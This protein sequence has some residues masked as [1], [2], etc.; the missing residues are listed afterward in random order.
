MVIRFHLNQCIGTNSPA[1]AAL[2][3]NP[4][5]HNSVSRKGAHKERPVSL[6][7][8]G[9]TGTAA[10][11]TATEPD[12]PQRIVAHDR[13]RR[14]VSRQESLPL[15]RM[16]KIGSIR[17]LF[18]LL[19]PMKTCFRAHGPRQ[20]HTGQ[21]SPILYLRRAPRPPGKYCS[22]ARPKEKH[23]SL[24]SLGHIYVW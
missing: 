17:R 6:K 14:P 4:E 8:N 21:A 19:L 7:A 11:A 20:I 22:E 18:Y 12:P 23:T 9:R 10:G 1:F 24:T 15:S 5:G 2:L 16:Q 3:C 13:V